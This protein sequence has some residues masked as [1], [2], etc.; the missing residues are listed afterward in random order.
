MAF[1]RLRHYGSLSLG[2]TRARYSTTR[3][4]L[5]I[6]TSKITIYFIYVSCP[7][8]FSGSSRPTFGITED[9][10]LVKITYSDEGQTK[11][12]WAK[13]S[14]TVKAVKQKAFPGKT[15]DFSF[16]FK[17]TV[18][19][20]DDNSTVR[21]LF[22]S[23]SLD[24]SRFIEAMDGY[25]AEY[26]FIVHP[27]KPPKTILTGITE[28]EYRLR[29]LNYYIRFSSTTIEA[30]LTTKD[31]EATYVSDAFDGQGCLLTFQ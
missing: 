12:L 26:P 5:A 22:D 29:N 24:I 4:L 27:P 10:E 31:N 8:F 2:P 18:T 13:K 23:I 30:D 16:G 20:I 9:P 28:G 1:A 14:D 21:S 25:C 19:K 6:I 3:K 7:V 17:S 11:S 15:D